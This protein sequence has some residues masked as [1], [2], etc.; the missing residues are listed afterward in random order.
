MIQV[1]VERNDNGFGDITNVAT[2][3]ETN[4]K[5]TE[6]SKWTHNT[7]RHGRNQNVRNMSVAGASYITGSGPDRTQSQGIASW[8]FEQG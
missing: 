2:P 5:R 1:R 6:I 7:A 3:D 4:Q 8:G